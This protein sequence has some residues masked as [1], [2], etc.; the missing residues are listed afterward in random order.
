MV[1]IGY[2]GGGQ[3]AA[4]AATADAPVRGFIIGGATVDDPTWWASLTVLPDGSIDLPGLSLA[5]RP[6]HAAPWEPEWL[7]TSALL[8]AGHIT[9]PVLIYHGVKDTRISVAQADALFVALIHR[10]AQVRYLRYREEDHSGWSA[11]AEAHL[12]EEV[13]RFLDEVT[14][15]APNEMAL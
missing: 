2:S 9:K 11:E 7:G 4:L 8:R 14:A 5:A 12:A 13:L 15:T 10:N 3:A 1:L 6:A